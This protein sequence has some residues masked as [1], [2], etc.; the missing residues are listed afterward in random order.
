MFSPRV[1]L[2]SLSLSVTG[3][4]WHLCCSDEDQLRLS[5]STLSPSFISISIFVVWFSTNWKNQRWVHC[6]FNLLLSPSFDNEPSHS[7]FSFRQP[8]TN[9]VWLRSHSICGQRQTR[10]QDLWLIFVFVL[11]DLTR[12]I[13]LSIIGSDS[14]CWRKVANLEEGCQ[15]GFEF[16]IEVSSKSNNE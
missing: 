3:I 14:A 13:G 11:Q 5:L 4:C 7:L 8:T 1:F 16:V 2:L 6:R 15:S 12:F 9:E 10:F